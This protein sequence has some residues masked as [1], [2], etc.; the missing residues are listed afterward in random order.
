MPSSICIQFCISYRPH[1][2]IFRQTSIETSTV[3]L[4]LPRIRCIPGGIHMQSHA[5]RKGQKRSQALGES[6][7]GSKYTLS[8]SQGC[9]LLS[10]PC[11]SISFIA[12]HLTQPGVRAAWGWIESHHCSRTVQNWDSSVLYIKESTGEGSLELAFLL[13]LLSSSKYALSKCAV[14]ETLPVVSTYHRKAI[15]VSVRQHN[16]F[17][18]GGK[19]KKIFTKKL[20]ESQDLVFFEIKKLGI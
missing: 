4:R 13:L 18:P 12:S 17:S 14:R 20:R 19:K 2:K 16:F 9:G 7:T 10:T 11:T 8:C 15:L 3:S 6:G 1:A 5:C